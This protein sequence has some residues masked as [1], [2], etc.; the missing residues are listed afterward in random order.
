MFFAENEIITDKISNARGVHHFVF[1]N[2]GLPSQVY[3]TTSRTVNAKSILGVCSLCIK[4]KTNITLT[5]H[6]NVSQ[7]QADKDL[8]KIEHWFN[9]EE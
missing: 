8:Q 7:E 5:V 4:D 6:S 3:I 1:F 9:G 2:Q